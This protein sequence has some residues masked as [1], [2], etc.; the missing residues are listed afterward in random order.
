MSLHIQKL[1]VGYGDQMV[2]QDFS[3]DVPAEATFGILGS[4]G[5]GKTTLFKTILGH[6]KPFSGH[7][8]WQGATLAHQQV[9][10]LETHPYFMPY[11]TA[12]EYLQLCAHQNPNFPIE[13]WNAIFQLP[14][15]QFAISFS[16]GMKKKLAIL[17]IIALDKPI[18]L[19]DEPFNG[20]DLESVERMYSVL[21]RLKQIGKTILISS[22]ILETLTRSCE[23]ICFLQKGAI[24]ANY[25]QAAFPELAA[26]LRQQFE[27]DT[28]SQLDELFD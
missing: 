17:G 12:R 26:T 10:Y 14:L 11:T 3:L 8:Q 19:L 20:L 13:K 5:A 23:K 2:L 4:N 9:A 1:Q 15:Q 21:A 18:L 27:Q 24:Q 25:D 6:K 16:T 7:L 22:H 28:E